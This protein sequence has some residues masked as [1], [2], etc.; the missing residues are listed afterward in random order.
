MGAE[1]G[2]DLVLQH[3]GASNFISNAQGHNLT[4][5]GQGASSVRAVF[6]QGGSVEL[7][8]SGTK[9]VETSSTGITVSG[10]ITTTAGN[11]S[12]WNAAYGWGNHA[13][14]NYLT[15]ITTL[16]VDSLSDVDTT[17][18]TPTTGQ[19]LKWDG[20]NWTQADETIP[21]SGVEIGMIIILS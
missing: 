1:T 7:Y 14:A 17:T 12:N 11:S 9:K 2:G 5:D 8:H 21:P 20:T 15:G 3:S 18:A 4:I 19:I 10:E 6:N 13:S 16:S